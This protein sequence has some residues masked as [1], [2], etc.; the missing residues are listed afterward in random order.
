MFTGSIWYD[1]VKSLL[2]PPAMGLLLIALSALVLICLKKPSRLRFTVRMVFVLG[3]AMSFILSTRAFGYLMAG[4]LEGPELRALDVAPFM[5]QLANPK[6]SDSVPQAIVVLGGGIR[7]DS[8]ERPYQDTVSSRALARLQH[9]AF[10]HKK[11]GLPILVTGGTARGFDIS[12]AQVMARTLREDFGVPVRWLEAQ[13][14][15]TKDNAVLS[16]TTLKPEAISRIVLITEAYHMRRSALVFA[17]NGFTVTKAP[18]SFRGGT[19]ADKSLA[20]LPTT[21]GMETSFLAIH[22]MIGLV[23][24]RSLGLI[25]S[26]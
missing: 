12:E 1:A 25:P 20:W 26:F 2:L 16:A 23:Q 6:L 21:S 19:D 3:L 11:T 7:H 4:L 24:Y 18:V 14:L 22:E 8:R 17:A 15:D 9:A 10:L 5:A 13:S